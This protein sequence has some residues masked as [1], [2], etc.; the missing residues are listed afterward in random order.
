METIEK[1]VEVEVPISRAY[2]QWTQFEEFPN[3]MEGVLSV[4]QVDDKHLH[5]VAQIG[6]RIKEWDS[7][8]LE[9]IPDQRIAWRSTS[10]AANSGVAS[11]RPIGAERTRINLKLSYQPEGVTEKMGDSLGLLS[12]RVE[13]D[14]RRFKEFIQNR[15]KETGAWRGEI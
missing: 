15:G 9:Q 8:I 5:W 14:L 1:S 10:G 7:E 4:R 6:G 11:F 12:Q 3:F 13:S 2:N